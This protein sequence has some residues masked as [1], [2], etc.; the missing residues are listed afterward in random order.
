MLAVSFL[1]MTALYC[2]INAVLPSWVAFPLALAFTLI[3]G[4]ML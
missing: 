3:I 1:V 2:G 4:T